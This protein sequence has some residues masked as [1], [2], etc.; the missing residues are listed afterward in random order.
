MHK[1]GSLQVLSD[2]LS[3][4]EQD[5]PH[6]QHDA[7]LKGREV[8]MLEG[9][10]LLVVNANRADALPSAKP[11]SVTEPAS[12]PTYPSPF[13][14]AALSALWNKGLAADGR[15]HEICQLLTVGARRAV[16]VPPR[17]PAAPLVARSN[18]GAAAR[19]VAH[20]ADQ[21]IHNF[22]LNGHPS[23]EITREI[24][25]RKF[26]WPGWATMPGASCGT[27]RSAAARRFGA[28]RSAA[29]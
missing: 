13:H 25:R 23:Q 11:V 10:G 3:Q 26:I 20:K 27:A 2:A 15:C 14:D 29:Y 9:E 19:A 24:M 22:P 6:D 12:Q 21:Q 16:W 28:N 5:L 1:P 7:R 8:Q 4:R 18:L 17:W